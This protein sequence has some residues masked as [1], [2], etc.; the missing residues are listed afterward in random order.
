MKGLD[1]E[2]AREALR[3]QL[4]SRPLATST[5][6]VAPEPP[7]AVKNLLTGMHIV[8]VDDNPDSLDRLVS[9]LRDLEAE[10]TVYPEPLEAER[11]ILRGRPDVVIS[12]ITRGIDPDGGF[13]YAER[14]RQA[15]YQ[16]PIIFFTARITQERRDR[17]A[18]LGAIDVVNTED[19]VLRILSAMEF[20]ARRLP[21]TRSAGALEP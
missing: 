8:C 12:D 7:L 3:T 11:S 15:G 13:T 5:I 1:S 18:K 4:A 16:G 17:A 9:W 20:R 6:Q 10:V 2:E 19:D 14:M 21:I